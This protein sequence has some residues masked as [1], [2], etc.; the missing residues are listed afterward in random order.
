MSIPIVEA[1][2]L[3]RRSSNDSC[4]DD[5]KLRIIEEDQTQH[6]TDVQEFKEKILNTKLSEENKENK[7]PAQRKLVRGYSQVVLPV[8][9]E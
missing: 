5:D 9:V 6:D 4:S 7:L 8:K 1:D 3:S 2:S